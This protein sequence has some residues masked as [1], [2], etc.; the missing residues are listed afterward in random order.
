MDETSE[1]S[2]S[3]IA[4]FPA[5]LLMAILLYVLSIGPAAMVCEKAN[6]S[7][8]AMRAADTFYSPLR[9]LEKTPLEKPLVLYISLWVAQ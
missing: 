9:W 3:W 8:G 4:F 7:P 1:K 6:I 2:T 5:V